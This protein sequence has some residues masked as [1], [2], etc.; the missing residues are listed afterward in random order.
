[1]KITDFAIRNVFRNIKE[2]FAYFFSSAVSAALLFSFTM[3]IFH[4]EFRVDVLPDYLK[5]ALYLLI[6]VTYLFLCFFVFY[7]VSIFLKRRY[8]EFGTLY[9]LG[10]SK[11]SMLIMITAENMLISFSS[12]IVGIVTGIVFSKFLLAVTRRLLDLP[13]MEFYFPLKASFITLAAFISIGFLISIFCTFTIRED[14]VFKLLKG[15]K[16]PRSEP[17]A[18]SILAVLCVIT[19]ATGY[20]LSVTAMESNIS[21]RIIPVSI[22][23]IIATYFL[24]SQLSVFVF[25]V[26]KNKPWLYRNKVNL[27]WVSNLYYRIKDNTMMFFLI[28]ITSTIAL[29]SIGG[30]YAYWSNKEQ[31]IENSYPQAFFIFDSHENRA[32]IDLKL[33]YLESSLSKSHIDYNKLT[34]EIKFIQLEDEELTVMSESTYHHLAKLLSREIISFNEAES[35]IIKDLGE[36]ER[37]AHRKVVK[38]KDR[39]LTIAHRSNEGILPAIFNETF[40]VKDPVFQS[41][42]GNSRYFAALDTADYKSTLKVCEAYGTKYSSDDRDKY[43]NYFLKAYILESTKIGYGFLLFSTIFIGLIFI[44]TTGSF[45]YNKCYMDIIEDRKK[46]KQLNKIGLTMSEI[47]KILNIEIG[48]IFLLPYI[49][50]LTHFIFAMSALKYA[51]G[52]PITS[53]AIKLII[54]M[55]IFQVIYFL[56]VK[57]N[58]VKEIRDAI[59]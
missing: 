38:L 6:V 19:I 27:L 12:G 41:L 53:V 7:S 57:A 51:F 33:I 16:K 55:L 44:V 48:V 52:V 50:S 5:K 46:Y 9:I 1:M 30:E 34:G 39:E 22:M 26:I 25:K 8:M 43:T 59:S 29:A 18:A 3:I 28:S 49:V 35:I 54:I 23:I 37:I 58:Y 32:D 42:E 17:K 11:R 4:P 40:I 56:F 31:E 2:Y 20:Y 21:R 15:T 24:F 45:I 36:K 13:A 14:Q 47:K 10:T